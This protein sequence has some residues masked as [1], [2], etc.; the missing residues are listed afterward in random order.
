MP[1]YKPAPAS[2]QRIIL[3]SYSTIYRLA[4]KEANLSI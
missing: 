3:L 1:P 4:V 2:L